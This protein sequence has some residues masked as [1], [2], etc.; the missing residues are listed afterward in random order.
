MQILIGSEIARAIN[1]CNPIKIAVAFIGNDWKEFVS[2]PDCL[3][4]IIV[5]PTLGSN[6]YAIMDLVKT[7]GWEKVLFLDELHAKTYIGESAAVIGSANLTKN[8]L[9]GQDLVELCVEFTAMEDLERT[10]QFFEDQ[11]QFAVKQYPH[12]D[13]KKRRLDTLVSM[14]STAN[15]EGIMKISDGKEKSFDN[16]DL[17]TNNDFYVL[18]YNEGG[19]EYSNEIEEIGSSNIRDAMTLAANDKP[20]THKWV[21]MWRITKESK[22]HKT[23]R[24]RWMYIDKI[25]NNGAKDEIYPKCVVQWKDEITERPPFELKDEVVEAFKV[26]VQNEDVARYL[27]QDENEIFSLEYSYKGVPLLIGR[28]KEYLRNTSAKDAT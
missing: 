1:Q 12:E 16:F 20:E 9:S 22:P 6:P 7:V 4:T 26:A 18:W 23:T 8:G 28:M 13:A 2:N 25:F 15:R 21:L 3:E 17:L 24:P 19:V 27:V 5:S 14:W 10:N 11:K